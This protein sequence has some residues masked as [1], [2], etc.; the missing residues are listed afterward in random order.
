[1]THYLGADL[2]MGKTTL[3]LGYRTRLEHW[4]VNH[5]HVRDVSH[6]LVLGLSL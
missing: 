1:M 4:T 5:L 2:Q 3:R 6:A